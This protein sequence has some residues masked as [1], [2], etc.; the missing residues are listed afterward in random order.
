M[1]DF[2]KNISPVELSIIVLI[3]LIFFGGKVISS[4]AKTSG[5]T[6]REIKKIKKVFTQNLEDD[7]SKSG[8]N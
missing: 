4:L 6:V 5:E 2:I 7:A 3:L 1:F 8:K